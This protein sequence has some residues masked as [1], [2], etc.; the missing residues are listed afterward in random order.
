M[1]FVYDLERALK[2]YQSTFGFE[3]LFAHAPHYAALRHPQL[4][5]RLDL[6]PAKP[7]SPDVGHG[8]QTYFLADDLDA[9][10]ARLRKLG[11][12]VTDPRREGNS[13]RFCSFNDCEGN[14]LGLTEAAR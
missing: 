5:F 12:A 10:V 1:L 3:T 2:W 4:N 9:E 13:P 6:H 7:G 14:V 8:A 11:V